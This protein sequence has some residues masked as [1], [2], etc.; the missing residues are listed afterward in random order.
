MHPA[1]FSISSVALLQQSSTQL[2]FTLSMT[3]TQAQY[4][5]RTLSSLRNIYRFEDIPMTAMEKGV[6]PYPQNTDEKPSK[7]MSFDLKCV[8]SWFSPLICVTCPLQCCQLC[9]SWR[10]KDDAITERHLIENPSGSACSHC[11]GQREREIDAH[12]HSVA[13]VRPG[14]WHSAYRRPPFDR[15][16]RVRPPRSYR[17]SQPG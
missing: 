4:L 9:I 10:P 13:P 14:L 6:I 7:G 16:Y 12:S 5:S 11:R 3:L 2:R 8:K 15:V 17:A 1:N